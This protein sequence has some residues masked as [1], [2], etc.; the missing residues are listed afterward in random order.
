M[1]LT[2]VIRAFFIFP[3]PESKSIIQKFPKDFVRFSQIGCLYEIA[4]TFYLI[5]FG[6]LLS[7]A[8]FKF[9]PI[10]K[11]LGFLPTPLGKGIICLFVGGILQEDW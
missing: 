11:Y 1:I 8:E 4:I 5:I 6:V 10:L 7:S 3:S 9:R 2:G